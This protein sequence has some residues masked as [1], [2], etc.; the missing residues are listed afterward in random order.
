MGIGMGGIFPLAMVLPLDYGRDS[1]D[2][3]G[4]NAM[5]LVIGYAAAAIAPL[6]IGLLAGPWGPGVVF[7]L[8][9][10]L[11]TVAGLLVL[12]LPPVP[13]R[14]NESGHRPGKS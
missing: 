7:P 12:S 9:A 10:G 13:P 3:A 14:P 1:D 8:I 6:G 2:V 11:E 4:L 5:A